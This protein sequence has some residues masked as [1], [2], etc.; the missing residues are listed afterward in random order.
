MNPTDLLGQ[1]PPMDNPAEMSAL[2]CMLLDQSTVPIIMQNAVADDFYGAGHQALF[3]AMVD[4]HQAGE[5][6]DTL[7]LRLHLQERGALDEVGGSVY[8]ME[9]TEAV[10]SVANSAYY[11]RVVHDKALSRETIDVASRILTDVAGSGRSGKDSAMVAIDALGEVLKRVKTSSVSARVAIAELIAHYDAKEHGID[12]GLKNIDFWFKGM[13]P[14]D[15]VVLGARSGHGKSALMSNMVAHH[16]K[17]GGKA[18]ILSLEMTRLQLIERM[19]ITESG[20]PKDNLKCEHP[21]EAD[22]STFVSAAGGIASW[23]VYIDDTPG[24][25]L[26]HVTSA[27]E[28]QVS[29]KGVTLICIDYLQLIRVGKTYSRE[30][31]VAGISGELKALAKRLNVPVVVLAQMNRDSEYRGDHRPKNSDLRE[32][33]AIVHDADKIMLLWR[34]EEYDRGN[35]AIRGE[36][37]VV[38]SKNRGGATG[39][40]KLTFTGELFEFEDD[41]F[42]RRGGV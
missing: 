7:S 16:A 32:S 20:V 5:I 31:A 29:D 27:A 28:Q 17:T 26:S 23:P 21:L 38:V 8:L 22:W 12:T 39:L 11:A 13:E 30:Q 19:V 2:G 9:L 36:A 14:G 41:M 15:L 24:M 34:A 25:A 40:A 10:P 18:L 33:D 35:A 3:T 37:E 42:P 1:M 6:I 4:M